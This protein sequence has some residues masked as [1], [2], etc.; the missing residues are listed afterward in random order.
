MADPGAE[1]LAVWGRAP[2]H[3]ARGGWTGGRGRAA[4]A[5]ARGWGRSALACFRLSVDPPASSLHGA[6]VLQWEE[7]QQQQRPRAPLIYPDPGNDVSGAAPCPFPHPLGVQSPLAPPLTSRLATSGLRRSELVG[8]GREAGIWFLRGGMG[9]RGAV[10]HSPPLDGSTDLPCVRAQVTPISGPYLPP[11]VLSSL[12]AL[13]PLAPRAIF[14]KGLLPG[15]C[16]PW[17]HRLEARPS[18]MAPSNI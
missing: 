10:A 3:R 11:C 17:S 1:Q 5:P 12:A 4:V 7:Q 2:R 13:A 15:V 14:P 16:S 9:D 8:L 6:R 18:L